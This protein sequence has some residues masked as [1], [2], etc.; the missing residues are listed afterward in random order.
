MPTLKFGWS[1]GS[2]GARQGAASE[3]GEKHKCRLTEAKGEGKCGEK[4]ENA[5]ESLSKITFEKYP[6]DL[7]VW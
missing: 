1:R 4:E 7:L 5:E 2:E 3:V 6:L